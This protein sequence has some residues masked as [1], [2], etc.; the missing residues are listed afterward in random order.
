MSLT[1]QSVKKHV[2]ARQRC[3]RTAQEPSAEQYYVM[4]LETAISAPRLSR[5]WKRRH[6]IEHCF[7]TLKHWLAT[8]AC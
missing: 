7:R 8:G 2:K 4:C 3:C 5:A 6:G 1:T